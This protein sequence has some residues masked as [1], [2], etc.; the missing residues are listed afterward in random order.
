MKNIIED[1]IKISELKTGQFDKVR[2]IEGKT[3]IYDLQVELDVNV[4][5]Y[6]IDKEKVDYF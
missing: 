6:P 5:V 3:D 2:R 4:D 1:T